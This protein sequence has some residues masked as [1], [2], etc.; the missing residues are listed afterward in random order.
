MLWVAGIEESRKF[1]TDEDSLHMVEAYKKLDARPG[2]KECFE[3]LRN[4]GFTVR[5]LTSGDTKRVMGYFER[6]GVDMPV[7]NFTS[8]D[9]LGVGKPDPMAYKPLLARFEGVEKPWFT[10][11]HTWDAGAARRNG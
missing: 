10:T 11:A 8:C 4:A 9:T 6:S 1:A 3:K 2:L 5:A 7:E